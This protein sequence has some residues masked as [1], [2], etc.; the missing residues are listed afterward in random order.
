MRAMK[1]AVTQLTTTGPK[2]SRAKLPR[3]TSSPKSA[4]PMGT[5]YAAEMPDAA[6]QATSSRACRRVTP[7]RSASH[8]PAAAPVWTSA[9]SRPSDAPAPT[10]AHRAL[11]YPYRL[12]DAGGAMSAR[13]PL[14]EHRGGRDQQS[15]EDGHDDPAGG[16]GRL[17]GGEDAIAAPP[18]DP[19]HQRE[20]P[21]ERHP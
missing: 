21:E 6:P 17:E 14:H 4:P 20:E 11:L 18:R 10:A 15:S 13:A 12:G 5:L 1:V 8:E 2:S 3:R 16:R 19:L 7:R 9:P